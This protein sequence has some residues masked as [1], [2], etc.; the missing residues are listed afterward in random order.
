M[1]WSVWGG[2]FTSSY[3]PAALLKWQP[4]LAPWGGL[5]GRGTCVH[6]KESGLPAALNSQPFCLQ[7]WTA[8]PSA[9]LP[10]L[11]VVLKDSCQAPLTC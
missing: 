11:L 6:I 3:S 2:R 9:W 4:A 1:L 7:P 10:L 8:S 5:S